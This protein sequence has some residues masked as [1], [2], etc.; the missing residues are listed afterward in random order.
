MYTNEA[1]CDNTRF[2]SLNAYFFVIPLGLDG[3]GLVSMTPVGES[4][5][6]DI[7]V[8]HLVENL[9]RFLC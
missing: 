5:G 1:T 4:V 8:L 3:P 6:E 2:K 7:G 9:L